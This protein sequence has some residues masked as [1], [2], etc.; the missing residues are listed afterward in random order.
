MWWRTPILLFILSLVVVFPLA[1]VG[2][3]QPEP[4]KEDLY[5]LHELLVDTIDQVER[6]YVKEVSRRQL[7][8]AAIRGVLGEL[9]PHSAYIG[10]GELEQFR[11]SVDSEFGG[12]GIQVGLE[13][14]RLTVISPLVGTPAYRAGVIA[15]DRIVEIDG[16]STEAITIEEAVRRLK[17]KDGTQVT[18]TVLHPGKNDPEKV[19]ITR[20]V[21]RV[22]TVLGG[23]RKDDDTWDYM[24]DA[25]K[26]IGYVRVTGFSRDTARQLR[27]ALD[28]LERAKLRGLILDLRFNPGGL[29]SSAVEVSD[30]FVAKGRIVSTKGREGR[31][32]ERAWEAHHKGTVGDVPMVVLVNRYSASASEIVSACLQDHKRAVVMGERTWGKGSVQNVIPLEEGRSAL[33]LT[34]A[35]YYRPSGKSIDRSGDAGE[36]ADWG[37]T[38]DK[39]YQLK[40]TGEELVALLKERRQRD[41]LRPRSPRPDAGPEPGQPPAAGPPET[42]AAAEGKPDAKPKPAPEKPAAG[43]PQSGLADPQLRM[44]IDYLTDELARA[45]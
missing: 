45:D 35:G 3:D 31:H 8:E 25:E 9:D 15:G 17:G 14:E 2:A 21:I 29:L 22:K 23:H 43:S 37:V 10:P 44:A 27:E 18:L 4:A 34:T 36:D 39:G 42:G 33:K 20:E 12:I 24:L 16:K 1:G 7:I 30:L 19:E 5:R 6:N 32:Q 38:P 41:I 11:D 26:R 40:L 13:G 28:E